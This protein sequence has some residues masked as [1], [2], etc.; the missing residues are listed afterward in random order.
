MEQ[1]TIHV[2]QLSAEIEV[3][4]ARSLLSES[5]NYDHTTSL[6]SSHDGNVGATRAVKRPFH[7]ST[8]NLAT[9]A[10]DLYNDNSASSKAFSSVSALNAMAANQITPLFATVPP[11]ATYSRKRARGIS[12]T[13]SVYSYKSSNTSAISDISTLIGERVHDY[14]KLDFIMHLDESQ[15]QFLNISNKIISYIGRGNHSYDVGVRIYNIFLS[16]S[17]QR[18]T[19]YPCRPFVLENLFR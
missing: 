5:L 19:M 2:P 7:S 3:L 18:L 6:T 11:L 1:F 14:Q 9:F 8:D 13:S 12:T 10:T 17:I 15:H 16:N 4:P